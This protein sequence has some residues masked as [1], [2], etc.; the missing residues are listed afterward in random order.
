MTLEIPI[1]ILPKVTE[2][3][4]YIIKLTTT[5]EL[6]DTSIEKGLLTTSNRIEEDTACLPTGMENRP[7]I[8]SG[9]KPPVVDSH[10]FTGN[11]I[12]SPNLVG[13]SQLKDQYTSVSNKVDQELE[14]QWP[15]SAEEVA[16][17][18]A[19]R[20]SCIDP[21]KFYDYYEKRGWKTG[22][23]EVVRN[24]KK[25]IEKWEAREYRGRQKKTAIDESYDMMK[26]WAGE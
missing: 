25:L 4:G 1:P 18:C 22:G 13:I 23:G 8:T 17:Y 16:E 10:A 20:R 21:E 15:A 11:T 5:S 2:L 7:D 19:A 3:L 14:I 12:S 24:W 6:K 9:Y 26:E